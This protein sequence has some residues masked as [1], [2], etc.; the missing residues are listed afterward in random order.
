M[1]LKEISDEQKSKGF[2]LIIDAYNKDSNLSEFGKD[3]QNIIKWMKK[4]FS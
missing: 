4:F 2:D 1:S 3:V